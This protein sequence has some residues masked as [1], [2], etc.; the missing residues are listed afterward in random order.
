MKTVDS[1]H[2]TAATPQELIS[3]AEDAQQRFLKH[4]I[5]N[6]GHLLGQFYK[7]LDAAYRAVSTDPTLGPKY[8]QLLDDTVNNS[9]RVQSGRESAEDAKGA[10]HV[11]P[12]SPFWDGVLGTVTTCGVDF[13]GTL[14]LLK[15]VVSPKKV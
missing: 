14:F 12:Y 5:L 7:A 1:G 6:E 9:L 11:V 8:E 2:E 4:N 15:K 3:A 13:E 10:Y